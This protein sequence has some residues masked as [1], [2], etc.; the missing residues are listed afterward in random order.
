MAAIPNSPVPIQQGGAQSTLPVSESLMFAMGGAINYCLTN[1]GKVGDVVMSDLS[2]AAFQAL[3]DT[4]WVLRDG[5]SVLGTEYATLTGLTTLPD[6]QGRYP[7]MPGGDDPNGTQAIGT[8]I[9]DQFAAH[10]HQLGIDSV[11]SAG[12]SIGAFTG[13]NPWITSSTGGTET[14]PKTVYT[15]FFVKVNT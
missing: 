6:Q 14:A 10:T 4:T 1:S 13:S 12:S 3:R 9:T 8:F 5:R 2:E 11:A 7:R 15:N